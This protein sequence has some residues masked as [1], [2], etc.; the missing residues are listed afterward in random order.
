MSEPIFASELRRLAGMDE[1]LELALDLRWS[2]DHGADEIWRPLA[3]ELWDLTR[4]PWVIL[5]TV[6]PGKLKELA[7]RMPNSGPG[8]KP[9]SR[10]CALPASAAA[11]FQK[12][13]AQAPLTTVAYFSMEFM[14]GEALPI[15]S[16]GLGNVAG[17]Q[18]KAASDLGVPV[19]GVGLLYQEGYFRQAIAADGSQL[20][21]YPINDPGQLPI[22]PVRDASGEWVRLQIH[23]PG[24]ASLGAHL[25]GASG[26]PEIISPGPERPGQPTHCARHNQ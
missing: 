17:D 3:P 7:A 18:L 14:L 5:Q 8:W 10:R 4:N 2:W 25:A 13:Q 1:L 23:F 26:P 11:W 16:G 20:A 21:L 24:Y 15:Y 9:W 6:A 22:T 19:V 12:A